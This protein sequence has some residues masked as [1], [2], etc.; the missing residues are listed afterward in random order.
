MS[1][2]CYVTSSKVAASRI[3]QYECHIVAMCRERAILHWVWNGKGSTIHLADGNCMVLIRLQSRVF[4][5]GVQHKMS[6]QK[7]L[8]WDAAV[9]HCS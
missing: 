6:W 4:K 7:R 1:Y 2:R 3:N 8:V 9:I 5:T